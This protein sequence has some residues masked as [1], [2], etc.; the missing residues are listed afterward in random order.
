LEK[1]LLMQM[2]ICPLWA[3]ATPL[4]WWLAKRFCIEWQNWRRRI[5]VP[6]GSGIALG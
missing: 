2:S 6:P 3:L 4:V 1:V 5:F